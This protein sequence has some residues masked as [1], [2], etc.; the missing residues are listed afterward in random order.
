LVNSSVSF[1]S[2]LFQ[3]ESFC[4]ADSEWVTTDA[5]L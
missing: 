1:G 4:L 3:P 5:L 2:T